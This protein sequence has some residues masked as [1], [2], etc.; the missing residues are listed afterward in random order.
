MEPNP[1]RSLVEAPDGPT[2]RD[3]VTIVLPTYN[4]AENLESMVDAIRSH[5]LGVLIVDDNSPD[6]TGEI[7]DGLAT[8]DGVSVLHRT[9]KQGLG[10]AYAAGFAAAL[11]AGAE[12]LCEMDA[13]FSHDPW[14]LPRLVGAID[15]GADLAIGSRYVAGGAVRDWPL[16]RRLL[17]RGG[18]IYANLM[19]GAGI[20]DMTSGFRAFRAGALRRLRPETCGASGYGFQIEMAW[21]AKR[22]DLTVV[23]IPITFRDRRAGESKMDTAI[24]LEAVRLVTGWGLRR[25]TGRVPDFAPPGE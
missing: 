22:A 24:A 11:D 20:S 2:P 9:H 6:G 15:D 1:G 18:N 17:S 21:R 7:A 14:D 10:P 8:A 25:L 5:G 16:S 13:D 3:D 12:I 4:E 19:L 23:E